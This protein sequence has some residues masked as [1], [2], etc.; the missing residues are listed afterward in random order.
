[1]SYRFYRDVEV[2]FRDLDSLG[3][4]H[5]S[6]ALM[7]VEEARAAYWREVAGRP[8]VEDIDY[9]IGEVKIRYH[10]R[11]MYPGSVRVGVRVSRIGGKSIDMEFEIRSLEGALLVSGGTTHIMFDF[12][13]GASMAVP[14]SLRERLE[15]YEAR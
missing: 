3:H 11:I 12:A 6:L 2:R 9:V 4:V 1:M 14:V 8:T 13:A 5:H 15:E 10:E 7:Y